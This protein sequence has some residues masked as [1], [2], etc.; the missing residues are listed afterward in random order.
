MLESQSN[1]LAFE[2]LPE[3]LVLVAADSIGHSL[4]DDKG[5]SSE[6]N[7]SPL[8]LKTAADW[9]TGSK[10]SSIEE[11][12]AKSFD[13]LPL[14]LLQQMIATY[15]DARFMHFRMTRDNGE[16][17]GKQDVDRY[18]AAFK[19]LLDHYFQ[20]VSKLKSPE[21]AAGL[22]QRIIDQLLVKS[23]PAPN[24]C[25]E[26]AFEKYN[27]DST[28]QL[29]ALATLAP[30]KYLISRPISPLVTLGANYSVKAFKGLLSQPLPAD[31]PVH[32]LQSMYVCSV[33]ANKK[34]DK[35]MSLIAS[36]EFKWKLERVTE[37]EHEDAVVLCSE[38]QSDCNGDKPNLVQISSMAGQ[39][40]AKTMSLT[41]FAQFFE[42]FP[43]LEKKASK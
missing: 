31:F 41:N 7:H 15:S 11:Q 43:P 25:K 42:E 13:K 32:L 18:L 23:F 36:Q 16:P 6:K 17:V 34:D 24:M 10:I 14:D 8:A 38:G 3:Q 9:L 39:N 2:S 35:Q 28:S 5:K 12:F 4:P 37:L 30:G 20:H 27:E 33:E 26:L 22:L 1:M 21:H 19:G 29:V 40:F